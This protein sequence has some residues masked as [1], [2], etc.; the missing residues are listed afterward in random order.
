[1]TTAVTAFLVCWALL[2]IAGNTPFGRLL[3]ALDGVAP[4]SKVIVEAE[5]GTFIDRDVTLAIE[6]FVKS[7]AAR[8]IEVELRGITLSHAE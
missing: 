7:A 4:G 3:H 1:M 5:P 6:S 8:T 2:A